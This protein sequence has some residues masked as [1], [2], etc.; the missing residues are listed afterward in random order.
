MPFFIFNLCSYRLSGA[1]NVPKTRYPDGPRNEIGQFGKTLKE[2]DLC[3][4]NNAKFPEG[5]RPRT[6]NE[7]DISEHYTP[8]P[9]FI[10]FK[11]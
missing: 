6:R 10:D 1:Y 4:K 2:M 11:D 8:L 5:N 9:H 7:I 3:I